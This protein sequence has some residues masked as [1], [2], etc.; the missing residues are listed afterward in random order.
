[1]I[2]AASR[3][4]TAVTNGFTMRIG[5]HDFDHGDRRSQMPIV[6]ANQREAP[7]L[8]GT[9]LSLTRLSITSAFN[10]NARYYTS[11]H[12][13]ATR[14]YSYGDQYFRW[15]FITPQIIF[16]NL[17]EAGQCYNC[18]YSQ[19]DDGGCLIVMCIKE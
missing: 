15:I 8:T 12:M 1:M 4:L 19:T 6:T 9:L 16:S 13:V 3:K 10:L 5:D 18:L 7:I 11:L 17:L 14:D 2:M